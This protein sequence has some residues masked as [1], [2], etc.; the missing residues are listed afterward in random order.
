MFHIFSYETWTLI[1]ISSFG[2][3]D[4]PWFGG[5]NARTELRSR[6]KASGLSVV[7]GDVSSGPDCL[8][9]RLA[10]AC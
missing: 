3:G 2:E 6:D 7:F 10:A 9:P 4:M 5:V 1:I 8:F